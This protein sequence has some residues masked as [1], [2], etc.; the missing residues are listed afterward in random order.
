MTEYLSEKLFKL[1]SNLNSYAFSH[2]IISFSINVS[3]KCVYQTFLKDIWCLDL[4]K[5]LELTLLMFQVLPQ[6]DL[7]GIY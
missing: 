3:I 4:E 2:N 7:V 6:V 1:F 5:W